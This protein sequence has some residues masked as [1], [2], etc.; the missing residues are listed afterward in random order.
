MDQGIGTFGGLTVLGIDFTHSRGVS[1]STGLMKLT[2]LESFDRVVGNLTLSFAGQSQT[3]T[4]V[5]A[6]AAPLEIFEGRDSFR[7]NVVIQDGRWRW[8]YPRITGTY[9]RR[10]CDGSVDPKGKKNARELG[11][12]LA[13]ELGDTIDVTALSTSVYPAV[14]WENSLARYELAWLCD[15]FALT[16][17]PRMDN[18]YK[19][20][21]I[22]A[23]ATLP[24]GG[25]NITPSEFSNK[26]GI[27]P[28]EVMVEGG[29][30][31]KQGWVPLQSIWLDTNGNYDVRDNMSYTPGTGWGTQ[32]PNIYP[33]VPTHHERKHAFDTGYRLYAPVDPTIILDDHVIEVGM[34]VPADRKRCLPAIV[35]GKFNS[36]DDFA[37]TTH[38]GGPYS[39]DFKFRKDINALEFKYPVYVIEGGSIA[40]AT[41]EVNTAYYQIDADSNPIGG[42]EKT[43]AVPQSVVPTKPRILRHHE[44]CIRE[45]IKDLYGGSAGSNSTVLDGESQIYLDAV[46]A[47]YAYGHAKDV[48]YNGLVFDDLPGVSQR[49]WRCGNGRVA[50]TRIGVNC[51]VDITAASN[52]QRRALE[53][54]AQMAERAGL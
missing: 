37:T 20:E 25:F 34:D 45:I 54:L 33:D 12:L 32:W 50:T 4:N 3:L 15:L 42:Y 46:V 6:A 44:L 47:C 2:P 27:M 41:L 49:K 23:T 9:N 39:G 7:W 13:T 53:R 14:V 16:V 36:H 38:G 43:K 11:E 5:S 24:S 26:P 40:P 31:K 17:A 28:S 22:T 52:Q 48:L 51:E 19:L 10:L 30:T 21:P 35:R 29:I 8:R 1:P 18:S